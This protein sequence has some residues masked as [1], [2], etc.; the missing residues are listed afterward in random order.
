MDTASNRPELRIFP[1]SEST[2]PAASITAQD[3]IRVIYVMG[4]GRSGSTAL[5]AMLG[6][7]DD[8][9]AVGEMSTIFSE[10]WKEVCHCSCGKLSVQCDLWRDVQ[11]RF[12]EITGLKSF[13][14]HWTQHE[15]YEEFVPRQLGI[16]QW[17]RL[18]LAAKSSER[19]VETWKARNLAVYQA[20]VD[21]TGKRIIVD[22]SKTPIRARAL[23]MTPGLDVRLVHLVRDVR[24]VTWSRQKAYRKNPALG[25]NKDQQPVPVWRSVA[26]WTVMNAL[27]SLVRRAHPECPSLL[28]RYE[29]YTSRPLEEFARISEIAGLDYGPIAQRLVDGQPVR[30]QHTSAGN[31]VRMLG[32]IRLSPDFEWMEKLPE[33]DRNTCWRL[34]GWMMRAYG[35]EKVPLINTQTLAP[36]VQSVWETIRSNEDPKQAEERRAA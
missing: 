21:V 12:C 6:D 32:A 29:D 2:A 1:Q 4:A 20:L 26:Y 7:H 3:P 19:D 34:A 10:R 18:S 15:Y 24:G 28:V 22:S 30:P 25:L 14:D 33:A 8:V 35:Y 13:Q 23:C 27:S 11:Q 17:M 5:E 31:P 16:P 9:V 36:R